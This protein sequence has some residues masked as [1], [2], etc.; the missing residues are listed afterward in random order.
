MTWRNE[1][2]R[3][4]P[5]GSIAGLDV[6]RFCAALLV[7][8]FHLGSANWIV[9][10]SD[11]GQA[12][13]AR[14]AYPEAYSFSWF[15]FVG[16]E[17]FFVISGVVIAYSALKQGPWKFALHRVLRLYPAALACAS[18]TAAVCAILGLYS[19]KNIAHRWVYSV[20]LVPIEP[21][22]D[23]VYWTLGIEMIFYGA[24]FALLLF[25]RKRL[26]EFGLVIGL[27]SAA[28]WL[29]GAIFF[30]EFI[31]AH[32]WS[33]PLELSPLQYGIYFGL[34]VVLFMRRERLRWFD[35]TFLLTALL[36]AY[37][38]ISL[39]SD[40]ALTAFGRPAL[41]FMPFVVFVA[42]FGFVELSFRLKVTNGVA[43][44]FRTLG[45]ATYPFYLLHDIVGAA[46]IRWLVDLGVNRWVALA[47]AL[48]SVA[49]LSIGISSLVEPKLRTVL[50]GLIE[51]ATK[52][53]ALRPASGNV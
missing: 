40:D 44:F 25:T 14:A 43:G 52:S 26:Y 46:A 9:S 12:L 38:E 19:L 31:R 24:V 37:V 28:Y 33:R 47:T 1:E 51:A 45:I 4:G 6:L 32:L 42:A 2:V 10:T 22:I 49:T 5:S 21:W 15:G 11:G 20:L 50:R 17:I 41:T 7:A 29:G 36:A 35:L 27:S 3:L 53:K 34:G 16:V 30:P 48:S 13:A 18:V 23:S 8:L 39:K